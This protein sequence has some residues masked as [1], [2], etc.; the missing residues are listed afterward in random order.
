MQ[1][2]IA[3]LEYRRRKLHAIEREAWLQH[4]VEEDHVGLAQLAKQRN[5]RGVEQALAHDLVEREDR[6]YAGQRIVGAVEQPPLPVA[7]LRKQLRQDPLAVGL[8]DGGDVAEE[9]SLVA[10]LR[11]ETRKE[12]EIRTVLPGIRS[13]V[14]AYTYRD[15][16]RH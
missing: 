6:H 3:R 12:R 7:L 1:E 2:E 14:R 15:T 13:K 5:R 10:A 11:H 8:R 16:W 9:A 4:E